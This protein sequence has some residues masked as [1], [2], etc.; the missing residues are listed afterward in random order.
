MADIFKFVGSIVT[1]SQPAS[2]SPQMFTE[3]DERQLLSKKISQD[4]SL[5]ADAPVDVQ[6]GSLQSAHVVVVK[7][8]RRVLARFTSD[9]GVVQALYIDCYMVLSSRRGGF[10]ALDLTR[11]VGVSTMCKVFLGETA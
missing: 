6:F 7:T 8:S 10:T 5:D 1:D 4:I 9:A 3:I 11:D 2:L